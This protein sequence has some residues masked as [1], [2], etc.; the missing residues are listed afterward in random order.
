MWE[1]KIKHAAFDP[2]FAKQFENQTPFPK[3]KKY[4]KPLYSNLFSD[5]ILR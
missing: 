2:F 4:W 1:K 3:S 5:K